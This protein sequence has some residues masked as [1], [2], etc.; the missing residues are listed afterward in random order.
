ME[1]LVNVAAAR[2][3]ACG[4]MWPLGKQSACSFQIEH[5]LIMIDACFMVTVLS[6]F[7]KVNIN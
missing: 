5:A 2:G 3:F 1:P 7:N 4:I 6:S